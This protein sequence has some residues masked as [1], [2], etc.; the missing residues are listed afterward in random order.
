MPLDDSGE[1]TLQVVE[2]ECRGADVAE[3]GGVSN[4]KRR[5]IEHAVEKRDRICKK[6]G[7]PVC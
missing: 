6:T 2:L 4:D 1:F 3:C 7:A 5:G